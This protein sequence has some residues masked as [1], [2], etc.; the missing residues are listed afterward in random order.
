MKIGKIEIDLWSKPGVTGSGP[1]GK[2]GE[3]ARGSPGSVVC[4]PIWPE[5][6]R[7]RCSNALLCGDLS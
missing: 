6:H 1:R 7:S 4:Q 2:H 5:H 3:D